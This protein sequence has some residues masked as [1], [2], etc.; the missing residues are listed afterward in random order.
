MLARS[1]LPGRPLQLSRY[2]CPRAVTSLRTTS[3]GFVPRVPTAFILRLE[4]GLRR[5][6]YPPIVL[7]AVMS[8]R[9]WASRAR[10]GEVARPAGFEPATPGLG[11]QCT[12]LLSYGHPA[13]LRAPGPVGY[14]EAPFAPT[15]GYRARAF[16]T[17]RRP[18]SAGRCTVSLS[19]LVPKDPH[20][21]RATLQA[22]SR[23]LR[24]TQERG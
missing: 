6:S 3:S 8:N 4:S 7:F 23:L 14:R 20:D 24:S 10:T 11:N 19:R 9:I 2:L 21:E 15:E 5:T 12:T 16:Y 17:M 18:G 22:L 1:G 13:K